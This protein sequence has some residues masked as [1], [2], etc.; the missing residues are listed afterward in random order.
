MTDID[1]DSLI[2]KAITSQ[3]VEITHVQ[4]LKSIADLV[5]NNENYKTVVHLIESSHINQLKSDKSLH[6]RPDNQVIREYLMVY[7]FKDQTNQ[8]YFA[9]FYDSDDPWQDLDLLKIIPFPL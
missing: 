2:I 3:V 1:F 4:G 7:S 9:V 6:E 5:Y 8:S